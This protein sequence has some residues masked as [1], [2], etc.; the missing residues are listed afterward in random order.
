MISCIG[1]TAYVL[2]HGYSLG[3][4]ATVTLLFECK[5][6]DQIIHLLFVMVCVLDKS[7]RFPL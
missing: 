7:I 5:M 1:Y 6:D 4:Y 3:L 2:G